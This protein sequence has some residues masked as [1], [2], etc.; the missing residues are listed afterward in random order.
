[1]QWFENR[2]LQFLYTKNFAGRWGVNGTYWYVITTSARTQWNPTT[3]TLQFLGISPADVLSQRATGRHR[4][5]VSAFARLPFDV[6]GSIY[7]SYTQGNR[8]NVMTGDFPL[9]AAAPTVILSNGRAV[10]DPFFNPAYPR[11]RKNDVDMIKADDT[12]V[13]NLRIEKGF[14]LPGARRVSLSVDVFNL[15]NAAAAS[16][17]LSSDVRAANFAVPSGFQAARV[18]QLAARFAF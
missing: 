5:R 11:A 6:T 16:S 9:N 8:S 15:F 14:V 2:S 12:H 10:S 18:G 7:Y 1:L 4:S 13:V 17:F 3:D